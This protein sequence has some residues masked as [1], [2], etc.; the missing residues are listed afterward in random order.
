M[1]GIPGRRKLVYIKNGVQFLEAFEVVAQVLWYGAGSIIIPTTGE[2]TDNE[3]FQ[4]IGRTAASWLCLA[5]ASRRSD[6]LVTRSTGL[7]GLEVSHPRSG[8]AREPQN[9]RSMLGLSLPG[10][11]GMGQTRDGTKTEE[12]HRGRGNDVWQSMANYYRYLVFLVI[13]KKK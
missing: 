11:S 12:W 4:M 13:Q 1:S 9:P 5:L 2:G 6:C 7:G 8:A 10:P 3:G